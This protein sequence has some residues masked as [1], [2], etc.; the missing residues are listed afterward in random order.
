MGFANLDF[1]EA[2]S[3]QGFFH[4]SSSKAGTTFSV[5]PGDGYSVIQSGLV[6]LFFTCSFAA[7][8]QSS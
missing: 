1:L 5:K 4:I 6:E 3:K 8:T 7:L 2:C